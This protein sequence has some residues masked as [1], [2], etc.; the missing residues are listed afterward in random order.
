M[1]I[2]AIGD[3][4]RWQWGHFWIF[5]LSAAAW[6]FRKGRIVSLS[7]AVCGCILLAVALQ[8]FA[9][10]LLGFMGASPVWIFRRNFS[11]TMGDRLYRWQFLKLV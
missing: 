4:H 5:R 6:P 9:Y 3:S 2:W 1:V 8:S 10:G 7:F 11:G